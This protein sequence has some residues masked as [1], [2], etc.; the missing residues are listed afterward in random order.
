MHV[1][2]LQLFSHSSQ[3][4]SLQQVL[5]GIRAVVPDC[6]V[7]LIGLLMSYPI[8]CSVALLGEQALGLNLLYLSRGSINIFEVFFSTTLTSFP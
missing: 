6:M 7:M 5:I 2:I 8:E 1:Q 4:V 3:L